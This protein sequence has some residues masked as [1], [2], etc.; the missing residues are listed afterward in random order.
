MV[1][2]AKLARLLVEQ[3]A[4]RLQRSKR[5]GYAVPD[6]RQPLLVD[7]ARRRGE[8]DR[9]P[10]AAASASADALSLPARSVTALGLVAFTSIIPANSLINVMAN[11]SAFVLI[12]VNT[13]TAPALKE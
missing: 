10:T 8:P 13:P 4:E 2:A 11:C 9:R 6:R 12:V 1:S 7:G 5:A 3:D